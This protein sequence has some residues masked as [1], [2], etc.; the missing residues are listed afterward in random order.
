MTIETHRLLQSARKGLF[1]P[2]E[3]G[4]TGFSTTK[5]FLLDG[6]LVRQACPGMPSLAGLEYGKRISRERGPSWDPKGPSEFA[7]AA[8]ILE[9]PTADGENFPPCFTGSK[10]KAS[11]VAWKYGAK[12]SPSAVGGSSTLRRSRELTGPFGV[13]TRTPFSRYPLAVF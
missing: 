3:G 6:A 1:L 4:N 10:G 8:Q 11:L 7:R 13:P 12:F 5:H 2:V 9:P